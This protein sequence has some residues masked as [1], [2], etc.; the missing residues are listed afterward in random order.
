MFH[1]KKTE[2][3]TE[4]NTSAHRLMEKQV[5]IFSFI[6]EKLLSLLFQFGLLAHLSRRVGELIV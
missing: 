2:M 5:L 6:Q 3:K 1:E 4:M